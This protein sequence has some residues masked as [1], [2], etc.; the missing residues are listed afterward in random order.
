MKK[1]QLVL[2]ALLSIV[3]VNCTRI[4]VGNV[5]L[6]I[7]Q[8]GDDRGLNPMENVSGWVWYN[9]IS[10]D[11]VEFPTEMQHVQ[12]VKFSINAFG[13]SEF[14]ITP[15][16][17]Y[18][19]NTSKADSIYRLFK[20]NNLDE[21]NSK[22]IVNS[23]YQA[24]TDVTGRYSPDSLLKN[25][26]GYERQVKNVLKA[27]LEQKGFIVDQVTSNLT[28][29]QVLTDAINNKNKMD[30]EAQ[31]VQLGV[32]KVQAQAR[33]DIAKARGDSASNVIRAAGEARANNLRQQAL[34][35]Y[36]LRQQML[37]KWDGKLPT[38]G[39]IPQMFKDVK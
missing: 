38:Y 13:G 12:C 16:V 15:N 36:L 26:E 25:R 35:E 24:F 27:S 5:G 14:D 29:P 7:S 39:A 23:I 32:I 19:I 34:T 22:Y 33:Q 17:N 3:L 37:D 4:G 11:V 31:Q 9:P 1:Y 2:L 21:I 6:K 10:Y 8:T 30:Q 20:T 28:P 18:F